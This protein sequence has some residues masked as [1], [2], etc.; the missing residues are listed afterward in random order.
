MT[1]T[2]DQHGPPRGK[3]QKPHKCRCA[4][5]ESLGADARNERAQI[6]GMSRR[7]AADSSYRNYS[8]DHNRD[9]FRNY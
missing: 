8:I 2:P 6:R 9:H 4:A 5:A 1:A 7:A 3:V